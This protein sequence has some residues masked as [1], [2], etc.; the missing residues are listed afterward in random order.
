MHAM[1]H[2]PSPN[3]LQAIGGGLYLFGTVLALWTS[4]SQIEGLGLFI[5]ILCLPAILVGMLLMLLGGER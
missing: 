5:I 4:L 3:R 2:L 1:K